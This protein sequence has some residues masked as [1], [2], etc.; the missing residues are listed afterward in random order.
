MIRLCI[1]IMK[2]QGL[3]TQTI[4]TG[5]NDQGTW[6]TQQRQGG[7]KT[8]N[9]NMFRHNHSDLKKK[10]PMEHRTSAVFHW[11]QQDVPSWE[12]CN[13]NSKEPTKTEQHSK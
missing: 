9:Q 8:Q 6:K 3:N 4:Q 12:V 7:H 10:Q 13:K 2:H 1:K 5:E 11:E